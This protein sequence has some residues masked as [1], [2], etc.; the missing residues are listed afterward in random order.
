MNYMDKNIKRGNTYTS[1]V[2]KPKWGLLLSLYTTQTIGISFFVVTLVAIL[3]SAGVS[4]EMLS[5]IYA[6][7]MI[8]PIKFLWASWVDRVS[9]GWLGHYRGWMILMQLG[10]ILTFVAMMC[11]DLVDDFWT[12]YCLC[13]F[14]AVFSAT[15]DIAVDATACK[16]LAWKDRG[17]GNGIQVAGELLG[18][19][20]G[21][22]I[23][24]MSYQY[25]GWHGTM[26]ILAGTTSISLI[27]LIFY[28]ETQMQVERKSGWLLLS[29]FQGLF[30]Q[31]GS[32]HWVCILLIYPIG[33]SLAYALIIPSLV[34]QGWKM[35]KIGLLVNVLGS[36][37][38]LVSALGTG[39]II[40]RISRKRALILSGILQILAIAAVA[41]LVF[42]YTDTLSV[43][44]AI[45]V[46]FLCYNP[47]VTV[48]ATIMMDRVSGQSPATEYTLQNSL[49]QLFS[50]GM[51][52]VGTA[53]IGSYGYA[54]VFF[55]SL[56]VSMLALFIS[57]PL[58]VSTK[59]KFEKEAY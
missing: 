35:E 14:V 18:H 7:G 29:T 54:G 17:I 43:T 27:Q 20:I 59:T 22:G 23:I 25:I 41:L 13:F 15:Q 44:V 32:K 16:I 52:S 39:W 34:D 36:I 10:M 58:K 47:T 37:V 53:M 6:L 9:F 46:Y 28:R 57:L 11:F 48:L 56:V 49:K 4:F 45:G 3:R 19:L 30:R 42:G 5:L 40:T 12:I 8:W 33:C 55:I 50:I 1:S 24:L 31:P 26:I 51:I 38:G 2:S 21:A